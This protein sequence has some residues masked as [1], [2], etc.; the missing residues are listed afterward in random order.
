MPEYE[1]TYN[2]ITVQDNTLKILELSL[3]ELK[4][5]DPYTERLKKYNVVLCRHWLS[6]WRLRNCWHDITDCLA[7]PSAT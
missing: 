1:G 6:S 7:C 4:D 3:N 2:D 5:L